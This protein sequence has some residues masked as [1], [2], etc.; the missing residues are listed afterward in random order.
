MQRRRR[1]D[2]VRGVAAGDLQRR[3]FTLRLR[4][5]PTRRTAEQLGIGEATLYRKLRSYAK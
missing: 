2:G 4:F 1:E 3:P 5:P